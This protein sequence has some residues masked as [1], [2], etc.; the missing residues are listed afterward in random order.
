MEELLKLIIQKLNNQVVVAE[1]VIDLEEDKEAVEEDMEVVDLEEAD[2]EVVEEEEEEV[3]VETHLWV[4][5]IKQNKKEQLVDLKE[6]K[7]N[8]E[9]VERVNFWFIMF[10]VIYLYDKVNKFI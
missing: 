1:E 4:K 9:W 8:F 3:E 10:W 6:R 5:K 2:L 7:W